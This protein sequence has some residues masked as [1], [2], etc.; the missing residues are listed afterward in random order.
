[1]KL[2]VP[3]AMHKEYGR[4]WMQYLRR[5]HGRSDA[6]RLFTRRVKDYVLK[7]RLAVAVLQ[8]PTVW[9]SVEHLFSRKGDDSHIEAVIRFILAVNAAEKRT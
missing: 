8:F 3:E 4:C 2:C 1:M 5:I 7:K 9:P 6:D